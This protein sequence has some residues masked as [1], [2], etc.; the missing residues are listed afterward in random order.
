MTN[1]TPRALLCDLMDELDAKDGLSRNAR[2]MRA[3]ARR[4]PDTSLDDAVFQRAGSAQA[5]AGD[6]A[7]QADDGPGN[8]YLE[9]LRSEPVNPWTHSPYN[10]LMF[11]WPPNPWLDGI[12]YKPSPEKP[13]KE[14]DYNN[15]MS[16]K[17]AENT[18]RAYSVPR[19]TPM[20]ASE[21]ILRRGYINNPMEPLTEKEIQDYKRRL[22]QTVKESGTEAA[23]D[24]TPIDTSTTAGKIAVMQA[25]AADWKSVEVRER[26]PNGRWEKLTDQE[27]RQGDEPAWNWWRFDYR[28]APPP[29][30]RSALQRARGYLETH[31][32]ASLEELV[33]EIDAAPLV[34]ISMQTI[35]F[36]AEASPYPA[37]VQWIEG[38]NAMPPGRY[39]LVRDDE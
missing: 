8:I 33:L 21:A 14:S 5:K 23:T 35:G 4:R 24:L 26:S 37:I 31:Q 28:I 30:A 2:A 18:K 34:M 27:P 20:T 11:N 3:F 12:G 16:A 36:G 38:P 1:L 17:H 7:P 32:D 22:E 9:A 15:M 25:H 29:A 13:M 10:P 19:L 6:P 39:R